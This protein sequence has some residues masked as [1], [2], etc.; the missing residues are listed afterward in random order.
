MRRRHSTGQ[1]ADTRGVVRDEKSKKQAC[2]NRFGVQRMLTVSLAVFT[3][4]VLLVLGI[5][6]IGLLDTF[7]HSVRDRSMEIAARQIEQAL[8]DGD[9]VTDTVYALAESHALCVLLFRVDGEVA[10]AV[11]SAEVSNDCII[12]HTSGDYISELYANA[13]EHGGSYRTTLH[14][15][16]DDHFP[17]GGRTPQGGLSQSP[18][19]ALMIKI[20]QG[21]DGKA[22]VILL[23][24]EL[25]PLNATI[26]TLRTQFIWIALLLFFG[27]LVLAYV[28]SRVISRPIVRMNEAAKLL[29]KGHY[30]AHFS[31]DGYLETREL[32]QTLNY[33]AGELSRVDG[34]QKEL[35]ANISHDLRTPLTMIK[36]YGEVMRDLPGENTPENVQVIIDEA[37]HLSELVN[38]LLDLSRLQSGM[39]TPER[40]V[41][42]L[43]ETARAVLHRY[44]KL[45]HHGGYHISF[46]AEKNVSVDADR[47][48]ILQ[49]I[50]NLINNAINYCGEDKVVE[51]VQSVE[52]D[53]T[54]RLSVRDH[55]AGIA[56][57]E[58][59]HIWDRY[60]KVDRVHRI[61][62]IGTG[63]G[64]S[65]AKGV[66]EA[67]GA[68]YGV[69]STQGEGAEFWF[70]LPVAEPI[71]WNEHELTK[72]E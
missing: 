68:D 33:A 12:H 43:T 29:A 32:A 10:V 18:V 14:M 19:S 21:A 65:I 3:G 9:D 24:A 41:F 72:E 69:N 62:M 53:G 27:V 52:S 30:D 6:Q 67:H 45:T 5:F 63:L 42:D 39:R 38:D 25:T 50:Y 49:V 13:I 70:V 26:N 15:Q 20:V 16:L 57:S 48:M 2:G 1:H 36:G 40:A 28:L 55:G 47:V 37:T 34:L 11:A 7:Y 4:F 23:D 51:V 22:Y 61:A 56:E 35:I 60:Y 58:L 54:V 31:G 59:P 44:D 66:L 64:L 46:E 71:E 8:A 17:R